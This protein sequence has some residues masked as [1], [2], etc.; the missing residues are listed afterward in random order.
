[1]VDSFKSNAITTNI[2]TTFLQ[3]IDVQIITSSH[4]S[5]L[6]TSLFYLPIITHHISNL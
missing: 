1:M 5:L 2:S 3:I 6:L 4:L